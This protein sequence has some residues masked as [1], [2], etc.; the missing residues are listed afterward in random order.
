LASPGSRISQ[1]ILAGAVIA[2][3]AGG[4]YFF[5]RG[6]ASGGSIEIFLPT[7]TPKPPDQTAGLKVYVSGAVRSPGVYSVDPESRLVQVIEAAGGATKDADL[8]AVNLAAR[9]RDED[10][11]HI[12]K[13]GEPAP[14]PAAIGA[15]PLGKIDLNSASLDLLKTL[16]GIGDV[17]GRSIISYRE[18]NGPFTSV[19]EIVRVS[20]IGPSTLE[21]IRDLVEAR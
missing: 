19:E 3:F 17:K 9:V 5:V 11:W 6:P 16:P 7:A 12:P 15:G 18:A 14:T 1:V 2:A 21:G 13:V 10:H 20:G 4:V 8:A